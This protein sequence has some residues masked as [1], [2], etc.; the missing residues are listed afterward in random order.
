MKRFMV[1][2]VVGVVALLLG[3]GGGIYVGMSFFGQPE[4]VGGSAAVTAMGPVVPVGDFT[5]NLSDKEPHIVKTT[6]SLELLSE[7]GA[8]VM[9]DA[10]W[11]VRIRNEIVLVI[12]DRRLDDLRSAEGVLD[13]AQD[14]KRRV[15]AL[16]PLVEGQPPVVRVLFQDFISQ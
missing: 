2:I 1:F 6:I 11:Q 8:L 13:L 3:V 10:G 16:L 4:P 9:A 12:K 7:K 5:V 15:N 14:I